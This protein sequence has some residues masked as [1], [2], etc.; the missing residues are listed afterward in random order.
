M[1]RL[2]ITARHVRARGAADDEEPADDVPPMVTA[3]EEEGVEEEL[4]LLPWS[5][6]VRHNTRESVWVVVDGTVYDMT[7]FIKEES[8]HPGGSEIPLEYAGKDATEFWTDMHG[9]LEDEIME[10]IDSN[11]LEDT[12]MADLGL[13][14]LPVVVGIA[15]GEAPASA[16]GPGFPTTNWAG[17]I[18]WSAHTPPRTHRSFGSSHRATPLLLQVCGG[19]GAA[20]VDRRAL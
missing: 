20:G 13:D 18:L 14:A 3:R 9:H 15:D 10:A 11:D 7:E 4:K 12:T 5:E 6:I 19:R 17:N 1:Q 8:G 16:R 2:R